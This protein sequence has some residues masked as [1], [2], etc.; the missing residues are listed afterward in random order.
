MSWRRRLAV[1]VLGLLLVGG[2]GLGLYSL[3][4]AGGTN[5]VWPEVVSATAT[6]ALV[7]VTGGYVWLTYRLVKRD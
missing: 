4:E 3:F 1:G 6:L 7:V 2:V 5:S